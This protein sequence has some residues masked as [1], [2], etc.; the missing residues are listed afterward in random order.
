MAEVPI[1]IY[2]IHSVL[3][4][5]N[6][7]PRSLLEVR[8]VEGKSNPRLHQLMRAAQAADIRCR[9]DPVQVLDQ[10]ADKRNHQ[11]VAALCRLPA[12]LGER[13]LRP[14]CAGTPI[15]LILDQVTDPLNLGACLRSA[16]AFAVTAVVIP[17]DHSA[18]LTPAAT[19]AASG[20]LGRVPLVRVANLARAMTLMKKHDVWMIGTCAD[21]ERPL[22]DIDLCRPVALV[23]GAESSGLRRRT[24]DLCDDF[25]AIPMTGRVESLNISAATAVGLYEIKRQRS[26]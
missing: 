4:M 6:S 22:F 18:E 14:L 1:W 8:L 19:K 24:A 15:F 10:L 2:G 13:D 20:A 12:C 23:M 25:G 26:G 17:T 3:A 21:A 16:E 9:F 5:I 7:Q 11:G